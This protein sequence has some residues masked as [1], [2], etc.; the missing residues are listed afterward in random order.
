MADRKRTITLDFDG[1]IHSYSS[2]WKGARTIVDPPVPGALN[3]IADAMEHFNIAILSSR[4]HQWG[5]RTAMKNW[6]RRHVFEA[7]DDETAHPK[8]H[9]VAIFVAASTMEPWDITRRDAARIFVCK[10]IEWPLFKPAS[11]I[12]IDDRGLNFNGIW[13]DIEDLKAFKPWN[14]R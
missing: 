4:S 8:L 10:K 9:K 7:M 13:P 12:S 3:F 14:K 1:V 5:G 6:L 11:H 2:G